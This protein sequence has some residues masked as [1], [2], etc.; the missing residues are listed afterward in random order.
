MLSIQRRLV[1]RHLTFDGAWTHG[2]YDQLYG[3]QQFWNLLCMVCS[4]PHE[5]LQIP[6]ISRIMVLYM[7][8]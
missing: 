4:S 3:Y 5:L 7:A 1:I 6:A 2:G 8:Q